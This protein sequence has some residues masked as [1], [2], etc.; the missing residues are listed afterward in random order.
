MPGGDIL[1]IYC[2]AC[3]KQGISSKMVK[4]LHSSGEGMRVKCI[5]Q[6]HLYAYERL[7][8]LNPRKEHLALNEKMPPSCQIQQVWVHPEAWA[9]LQKRFP[10]NLMTTLCATITALADPDTVMVEGEHAREMRALG[11]ERGRDVLALAKRVKEQ[12]QELEEMRIRER[13]LAP[14]LKA[15]GGA[16]GATNLAAAQEPS[17]TVNGQR[18]P[19]LPAPAAM[20]ELVEDPES[21]LLVPAGEFAGQQTQARQLPTQPPL[22]GSVSEPRPPFVRRMA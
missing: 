3:D 15:L 12:G 19:D 18:N 10:Q 6:G 9:M 14:L 20:E 4:V 22:V 21:G 8:Q 2:P 7:M 17:A 16:T 5:A 1:P 11:V 13:A